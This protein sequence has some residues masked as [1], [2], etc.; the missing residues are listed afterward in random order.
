MHNREAMA[1]ASL[2]HFLFEEE[3]NKLEGSIKIAIEASAKLTEKNI[4]FAINE[5]LED[6]NIQL[7]FELSMLSV[8]KRK[9]DEAKEILAKKDFDEIPDEMRE[10]I[11]NAA[12]VT[13]KLIGIAQGKKTLKGLSSEEKALIS[14]EFIPK[15][16]SY[17]TDN[18]A[19][20]DNPDYS[21]N[22]YPLTSQEIKDLQVVA[23]EA[24]REAIESEKASIKIQSL[25]R[26]ISAKQKTEERKLKLKEE[27]KEA[28]K[29]A[30]EKE[31]KA[32][33]AAKAAKISNIF[34]LLTSTITG[35]LAGIYSQTLQN[36][37]F[38]KILFGKA[39]LFGYTLPAVNLAAASIAF[40]LVALIA[41][42]SV[43]FIAKLA[44]KEPLF[45][46]HL[47]SLATNQSAK[48]MLWATLTGIIFTVF[49][50]YALPI[51]LL[52]FGKVLLGGTLLTNASFALIATAFI[53]PTVYIASL[54]K[55]N[56]RKISGLFTFL[57]STWFANPIMQS[58][59]GITITG[60]PW[61]VVASS[62]GIGA[63]SAL[64]A[65]ILVNRALEA[66][67]NNE[68]DSHGFI[69]TI[70]AVSFIALSIYASPIQIAVLGHAIVFITPMLSNISFGAILSLITAPILD[71]LY[72]T[73]ETNITPAVMDP[74]KAAEQLKEKTVET[75]TAAGNGLNE[76]LSPTKGT[77]SPKGT[78]A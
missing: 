48:T 16:L 60:G 65:L 5:D 2:D 12:I 32:A 78:E 31:A 72:R 46:S 47:D 52:F 44:Q 55:N 6:I 33:K 53:G 68:K 7:L 22:E 77:S 26:K 45:K 50:T 76:L 57:L 35:I 25:Q 73:A 54:H 15:L 27:K 11:I 42:F 51:Q 49:N 19:M 58:L 37:L 9:G 61:A 39:M 70:Y 20:K 28:K 14:K 23:T 1:L 64:L 29:L 24:N 75:V 13:L 67:D 66:I 40:G 8:S 17:I 56:V 69:L 21:N 3:S 74:A 59:F 62:L 4:V 30:D 18:I 43:I 34:A 71:K 36:A 10:T 41:T 38:G 63:V